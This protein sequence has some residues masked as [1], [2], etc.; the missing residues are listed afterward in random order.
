MP[1]T[2]ILVELD[3]TAQSAA[4]LDLSARH[5]AH[6]IGLFVIPPFEPPMMFPGAI[7]CLSE[8]QAEY[9]E[10]AQTDASTVQGAFESALKQNGLAG[11]WRCLDGFADD[12]IVTHARYA[13]FVAVSQADPDRR[14]ASVA[15]R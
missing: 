14:S 8:I 1:M 6:L 11:E 2:T 3:S 9:R 15:A 4:R 12:V 5:D 7:W 13:D 10:R